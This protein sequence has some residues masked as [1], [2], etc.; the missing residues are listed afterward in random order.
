MSTNTI[1]TPDTETLTLNVEAAETLTVDLRT[2]GV[3]T[4]E[5][6]R[7]FAAKVAYAHKSNVAEVLGF[8][9][10]SDYAAH[11]FSADAMKSSKMTKS[12][13]ESLVAQM[14]EAAGIDAIGSLSTRTLAAMLGCSTGTASYLRKSLNLNTGETIG[15][16]GKIY[17]HPV[18]TVAP[19]ESDA[20]STDGEPAESKPAKGKAS[21]SGVASVQQAKTAELQGL[22]EDIVRE[23]SS[24]WSEG[25]ESAESALQ[26]ARDA[27]AALFA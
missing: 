3:A 19:A 23:L 10:W 6:R 22:M 2:L 16:D 27:L 1:A 9:G 4:V 11:V 17:K 5:A 26:E 15:R 13:R 8:N 24:R 18:K 7:A 25:D 12:D 14:I 20:E 21:K